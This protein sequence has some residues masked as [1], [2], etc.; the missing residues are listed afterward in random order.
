MASI[1]LKG[2][3][4]T[5][6]V[7]LLF[8]TDEQCTKEFP[9]VPPGVGYKTTFQVSDRKPGDEVGSYTGNLSD[10]GYEV[11]WVQQYRYV[12]DWPKKPTDIVINR[13]SWVKRDQVTGFWDKGVDAPTPPPSGDDKTPPPADNTN[14]FLGAAV[15]VAAFMK[16]R[17]N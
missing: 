14:L 5:A 1:P 12:P 8:Y 9:P 16:F 10:V 7:R 4:L 17:K 6:K 15:A 2:D 3:R 11:D 13:R